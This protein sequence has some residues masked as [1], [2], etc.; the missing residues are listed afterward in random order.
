MNIIFGLLSLI[1][2]LICFF[3]GVYYLWQ[4]SQI[5]I[6]VGFSAPTL[7]YNLGSYIQYLIAT[8]ITGLI[9]Q[10]LFAIGSK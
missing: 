6:T 2:T 9:T 10:F 7:A 4:V 3:T 8:V 1:V 5:L